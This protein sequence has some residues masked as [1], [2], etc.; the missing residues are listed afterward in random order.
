LKLDLNLLAGRGFI[1][2]GAHIGPRGIS[3]SNSRQGKI[4]SGVISADM[5][6]PDHAWFA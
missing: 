3:W 1:K 2:F 5:T 4:A 6:N